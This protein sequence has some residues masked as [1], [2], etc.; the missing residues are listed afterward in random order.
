MSEIF[1]QDFLGEGHHINDCKSHIVFVPADDFLVFGMLSGRSPTSRISYVFK[2][3][4]AMVSVF[5]PVVLRC[6]L[7]CVIRQSKL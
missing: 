3:N 4:E 1:G 5:L 7:S 6:C 2:R